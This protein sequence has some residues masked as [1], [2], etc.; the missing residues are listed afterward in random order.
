MSTND[1]TD[2][3]FMSNKNVNAK[4]EYN[5]T[6]IGKGSFASVYL[7]QDRN[8][9]QVAIK[10]INI[11]KIS[12]HLL[13]K[14]KLEMDIV[15]TLNHINI[16]KTHETFKT[17]NNIYIVMEYC[18]NETLFEYIKENY[19]YT[20]DK[21]KNVLKIINQIKN[22]FEYLYELNIFHRDLK[23]KN[24]LIHKQS[25]T[26]LIVKIADFGFAKIFDKEYFSDDGYCNLENTFCGTPL[27]MAPEILLNNKFNIK[28][29][30][31][32]IGVIMYEM[33]YGYVPYDKPRNMNELKKM[34]KTQSISFPSRYAYFSYNYSENVIALV[35]ILLHIDPI[36]RIDW[37]DFFDHDAFN[38]QN[39]FKLF[40]KPK[41]E[42]EK[43]SSNP[44]NIPNNLNV[45]QSNYIDKDGEEMYKDFIVI[46]Q[47]EIEKLKTC[48]SYKEE[49]SSIIKIV[50]ESYNYLFG[51]SPKS[52]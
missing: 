10:K 38:Y 45:N 22:A 11:A 47:H 39:S 18:N 17:I 37:I 24:I 2:D 13:H 7:G 14:F 35:K 1:N 3:T 6:P 48:Y 34:I 23:P 51:S 31:W 5:I 44:I 8:K 20:V 26:I 32:S 40:D 9:K 15:K 25:E 16:V 28:C 43:K 42:P 19:K 36:K 50:S 41:R 33:L 12:I 52:V 30:L 46:N 49:S 4:Y 21:E 27:Y 29:D